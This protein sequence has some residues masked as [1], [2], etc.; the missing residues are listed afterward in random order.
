MSK[1][2]IN[3]SEVTFIVWYHLLHPSLYHQAISRIIL[4]WHVVVYYR[5]SNW[6]TIKGYHQEWLNSHS[7]TINYWHT[8]PARRRLPLLYP[9]KRLYV[10]SPSLLWDTFDVL[11]GSC[12]ILPI[13][14]AL[15]QWTIRLLSGC[16][17]EAV[18]HIPQIPNYIPSFPIIVHHD[19]LNPSY[20]DIKYE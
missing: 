4:N 18:L 17:E 1:E 12:T 8:R 5:Y 13:L 20:W 7:N 14:Y 10:I 3:M 11:K 16:V 2:W 9:H 6:Q 15:E 19:Y